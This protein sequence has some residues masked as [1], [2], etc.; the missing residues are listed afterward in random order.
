ML[1]IDGCYEAADPCTT[2]GGSLTETSQHRRGCRG[3]PRDADAQA[4]AAAVLRLGSMFPRVDT[5]VRKRTACIETPPPQTPSQAFLPLLPIH[6]A[7]TS[8]NTQCQHTHSTPHALSST[9]G[10]RRRRS[11]AAAGL[12]AATGLACL[13]SCPW[14]AAF[15]RNLQRP[16]TESVSRLRIVGAGSAA[17]GVGCVGVG[18]CV[19]V[20]GG[21][22]CETTTTCCP[23]MD[24]TRSATTTT[25]RNRHK[26][27]AVL[28][29]ACKISG[30]STAGQKGAHSLKRSAILQNSEKSRLRQQVL[31]ECLSGQKTRCA[32][33]R[34]ST[35]RRVDSIEGSRPR[36]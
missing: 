9:S 19:C 15:F 26:W 4:G 30:M 31:F 22:G 20:G 11:H 5:W 14:I 16:W 2:G 6:P 29:S 35:Q 12:Y 34:R 21:R 33:K 7:H 17:G 13:P 24:P 10:G 32:A 8:A 27:H 3:A 36:F 1:D 23:R 25:T 28:Q 18:V